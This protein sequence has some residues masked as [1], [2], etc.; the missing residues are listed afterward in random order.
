MMLV[1]VFV[2]FP[3][4]LFSF[5][6]V[7]PFDVFY[8]LILWLFFLQLLLISK[9]CPCVPWLVPFVVLHVTICLCSVYCLRL[10]FWRVVGL[11]ALQLVVVPFGP[12]LV[13]AF[14]LPF[15]LVVSLHFHA[16]FGDPQIIPKSRHVLFHTFCVA[17]EV[18]A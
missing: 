14:F 10:F 3:P 1:V 17:A 11:Y 15:S 8:L 5:L 2:S 13:V 9:L 16:V 12:F 6:I 4:L 7:F 18:S